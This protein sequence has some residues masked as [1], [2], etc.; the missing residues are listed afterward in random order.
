MTSPGHAGDRNETGPRLS[1]LLIVDDHPIVRQGLAQLIDQEPDLEVCGET[2][3]VV[4]AL[5][6]IERLGPD[7]VV[8][9][10]MLK[11]G[12]GIELIKKV[13][14]QW[15]SLPVLVMSM[16]DESLYAERALRAGAFG[17]IMKEEATDRMLTAIRKVLQ[18]EIYLSEKMVSRILHR[19]VEGKAASDPY[20]ASL[21]DRELQVFHLIG[22][23][24][25]SRQI[26]ER[27]NV[28]IKTVESYRA[29]I[30]DKLKLGSS[31]EVVHY[32]VQWTQGQE[33]A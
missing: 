15:Q 31:T 11:T 18:G 33:N 30:K 27:L 10:I 25:G 16:Y 20:L 23:G 4:P 24:L 19:L 21:T 26:A 7:L 28:S 32:A 12:N 5:E 3:D 22:R 17:Y 6:A 8:V 9:D 13:K 1:R 2:D 29:H 14:T